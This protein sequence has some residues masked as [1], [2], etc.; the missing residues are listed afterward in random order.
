MNHRKILPVILYT[1]AL[2]AILLYPV[3][4]I[5][6]FEFPA[7]PPTEIKFKV[8][9]YDPYDPMRGRFVRLQVRPDR[10]VTAD[11]INRFPYRANAYIVFAKDKNAYAKL[12]R[13]EK[14]YPKLKKGEFA[15]K[16]NRVWY[17]SRYK[18]K[19]AYYQFVWPFDRFYLNELKAPA[20]EEEL[21]KKNSEFVLTVQFFRSG[22]FAVKNLSK[23]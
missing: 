15:L 4:K 5:L 7:E 8:N 18:D 3:E 20:L 14:E 6:S 10:F 13:L 12:L 19:S 21:R 16:V 22:S 11:K 23:Q 17:S 1:L 9:L 2:A